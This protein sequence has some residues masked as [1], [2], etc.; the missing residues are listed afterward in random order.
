MA[1]HKSTVRFNVNP[2]RGSATA[3]FKKEF[4]EKF[5]K[6]TESDKGLTPNKDY[7]VV[8]DDEKETLCIEEL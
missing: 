8:W 2:E 4:T 7:K 6:K 3:Y 1:L 5:I